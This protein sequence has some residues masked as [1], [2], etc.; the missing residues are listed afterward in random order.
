MLEDAH[1]SN[2]FSVLSR[3]EEPQDCP[4]YM[5]A[6]RFIAVCTSMEK[7]VVG[8]LFIHAL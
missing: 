3:R 5:S 4:L 7:A 8:S 2:R 1:T 6:V